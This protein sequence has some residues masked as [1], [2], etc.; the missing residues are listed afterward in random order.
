[1]TVFAVV[2]LRSFPSD[3]IQQALDENY[4]GQYLKVDEG[5]W[6]LTEASGTSM[7]VSEKLGL[8]GPSNQ[9]KPPPSVAIVYNISGY[10]GR[11]PAPVWEWL[12]SNF[13]AKSG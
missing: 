2:S 11:A 3:A 10:F 7:A 5:H 6:L 12:K 9:D 1:M 13:G 8:T 4:A